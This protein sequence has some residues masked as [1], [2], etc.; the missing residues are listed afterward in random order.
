MSDTHVAALVGNGLS[1]SVNNQM[2]LRSITTEVVARIGESDGDDVSVA[3]RGIA[4]RALPDG[5]GS[6]GDFEVLLGAF[7]A[8]RRNLELLE[9][10]SAATGQRDDDELQ[11]AIRRTARFAERVRDSGVSHALEVIAERS[12]ANEESSGALREFV[13][14]IVTEFT[15]DVSFG[16]LNYDTLLLASLLRECKDEVADMGHGQLGGELTIAHDWSIAGYPLRQCAD[17]FPATHRVRLLHLH[18]SLAY[19]DDGTGTHLK[20]SRD[21][22]T[23]ELWRAVRDGNCSARP[24]VVLTTQHDKATAVEATPFRLPYEMF[25]TALRG[26]THWLIVGYSFRDAPV[27][28]M[29]R[30][31]FD[32]HELPKVLV[33]TH[34]DSPTRSEVERA[35]G[36]DPECDGNAN[37][38][39]IDRE[40]AAGAHERHRWSRFVR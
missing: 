7:D 21:R 10:L 3:M 6:D 22:V 33:I 37:W 36:W 8:E 1:I 40:G 19:W 17:D 14:A 26:S 20:I 35:L 12:R 13:R 9:V 25:G 28:K 18:G 29:L 32:G 31:S 34:G 11:Q 5:A 16:N 27:N 24:D 15:G 4:D 23:P 39:S 2:T 38:L 30:E